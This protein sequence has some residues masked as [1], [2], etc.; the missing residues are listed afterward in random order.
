[1]ILRRFTSGPCQVCITMRSISHHVGAL[2]VLE[3][4][5][6]G[7]R[8]V[9]GNPNG[10]V[11]HSN[12]T[13]LCLNMT[14]EYMWWSKKTC[15]IGTILI[16]LVLWN[17][18]HILGT[19]PFDFHIFQRSRLNHPKNFSHGIAPLSWDMKFIPNGWLVIGSATWVIDYYYK[20]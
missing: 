5:W 18:F 6:S 10:T 16:C 3:D 13:C 14:C 1:M 19:I 4:G 7:C 20:P 17:I 2:A 9:I 15:L 8:W 11:T 12:T